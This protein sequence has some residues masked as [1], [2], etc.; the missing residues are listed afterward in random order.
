MISL[1][2]G[3]DR[4]PLRALALALGIGV[5]SGSS[6]LAY[7]EGFEGLGGMGQNGHGSL[8]YGTLGS[9]GSGLDPRFYGFGLSYHLGY[10]YG[11]SG[12]GVGANGGYPYYGGP[13]YPHPWPRLRRFCG[14]SPFLFDGGPGYPSQDHP[15]YFGEI[16]QLVVDREVA[17]ESDIPELGSTRDY[18]CFTGAIPYPETFFAPYA[19]AAAASGSAGARPLSPPPNSGARP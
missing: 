14:I 11:G 7:G 8:V 16:G 1:V 10:G 3:R 9:G 2:R 15:N 12:L 17:I 18:G 6:V 4:L 13:G 19:T 5:F